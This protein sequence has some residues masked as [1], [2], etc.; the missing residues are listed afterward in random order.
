MQ[1][2]PRTDGNNWSKF[3]FFQFVRRRIYS[4]SLKAIFS[5][6]LQLLRIDADS[7]VIN[8]ISEL[9][10]VKSAINLQCL[11]N[12]GDEVLNYKIEMDKINKCCSFSKRSYTLIDAQSRTVL[13]ACGLR[14][15][16]HER[17]ILD[18]EKTVKNFIQ[19]KIFIKMLECAIPYQILENDKYFIITNIPYGC[20]N[21]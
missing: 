17:Y 19:N 9:S 11:F 2:Y 20:K 7:L 14:I 12:A 6:S 4:D 10:G 16:L 21:K 18:L 5:R 3:I 13:K 1:S 15:S 8:N